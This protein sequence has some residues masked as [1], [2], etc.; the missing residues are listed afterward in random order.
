MTLT[1]ITIT[2]SAKHDGQQRH[3]VHTKYKV[4]QKPATG[5]RVSSKSASRSF[6]CGGSLMVSLLKIY[7]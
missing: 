4:E 7:C 1:M 6:R 5:Q 3:K 2:L